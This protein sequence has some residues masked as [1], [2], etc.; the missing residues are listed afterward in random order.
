MDNLGRTTDDQ[1]APA[2]GHM[3]TDLLIAV[4]LIG[5]AVVGKLAWSVSDGSLLAALGAR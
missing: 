2:T 1:S 5:V 4:G 3:S